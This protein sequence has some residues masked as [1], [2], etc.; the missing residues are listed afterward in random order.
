MSRTK[1]GHS[2]TPWVVYDDGLAEDSSDIIMAHIDGENYDIAAMS[3][4]LPVEVRKANAAHI[5]RCVNSHDALL[6][7]AEDVI[8]ARDVGMGKSAIDL[9][10]K[11]LEDA[12]KAAKGEE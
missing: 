4:E 12:V 3:D 7:A 2:V 9:R 10:Y 11:L 5:V 8:K 6:E 1:Q